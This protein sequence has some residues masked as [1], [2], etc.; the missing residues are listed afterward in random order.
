VTRLR[1]A[2]ADPDALIAE[3]GNHLSLATLLRGAEC[4]GDLS[5]TWVAIDGRHQR[6]RTSRST[7]VY[8]VIDGSLSI[9]CADGAPAIL[10]PGEI[11]AIPRGMSYALE[12]TA[13]YLVINGPA[14]AD[15][16]DEYLDASD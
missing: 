5:I 4:D 2:R 8:A 15:G 16:D 6:L 7:R 11:A 3:P 13:T 14:F 9:E 1:V 10:G 12:G